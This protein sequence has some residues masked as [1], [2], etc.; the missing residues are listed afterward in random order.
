MKQLKSVIYVNYSPYENSGKILDFLLKNFRYVFLFSIGFYKLDNKRQYN[1]L[2]VYRDGKLQR[3][4]SLFYLSIPK[5]LVF[6][7][8]RS[9]IN[10]LQISIYSY[11][12]S[13]KFGKIYVYFTVNAF[14][15]WVGNILKGLGL[16]EKTVFWVWDYYPPTHKSKIITIMRWV[17]WQFDKIS[18]QSDRVAYVNKRLMDLRKDIG[19]LPQNANFP[20]VPIGTDLLKIHP[21][22]KK[23]VTLGFIGVLKKSQGLDTVFDNA[24][25]IIKVFPNAKLEIVGS[26]P[27]E[28]Y[29]KSKAKKYLLP[30]NFHGYMEAESF[31]QVLE[32]CSIGV[33]TYSPDP[34]NVAHFG[35]AGKVKQYLSLGLPV[36]ITDIFEFARKIEE[37]KAGVIIEYEKPKELVNAIRK[38]MSNYEQYQKNALKVS[39][40]L[41][42]KKI[43]PQMFKFT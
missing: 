35:D 31:D 15:A 33:A 18:T 7:P 25:S 41:F 43:Y 37:N 14:T 23:F 3:E 17:Y 30:T 2:L 22:K 8:V 20:I 6:L 29:F 9:L 10:F 34:S 27:D 1:R 16:V 21:G 24:N 5:Q 12:L 11:W 19:I 38:I 40:T 4:H 28:D 13:K 26:G 42:Y 39:K 32:K 36:I